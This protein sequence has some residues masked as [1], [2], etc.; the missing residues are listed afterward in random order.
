MGSQ[1]EKAGVALFNFERIDVKINSMAFRIR[2]ER[3]TVVLERLTESSEPF[4][5]RILD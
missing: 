2:M 1:I 5:F 4:V 3:H